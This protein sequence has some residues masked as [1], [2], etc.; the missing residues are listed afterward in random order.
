MAELLEKQADMIN[1][2][3]EHNTRLN[4]KL[5]QMNTQLRTVTLPAQPNI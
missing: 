1:Y 3:K 5:M 4:Q 2:L